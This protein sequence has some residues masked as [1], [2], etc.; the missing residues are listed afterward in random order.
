MGPP[1]RESGLRYWRLAAVIVSVVHVCRGLRRSFYLDGR[2]VPAITAYLF[3]S[4]GH[5]DPAGN[6]L[7]NENKSFIGSYLLGMGF[8]F[9]DSGGQNQQVH[10]VMEELIHIEPRN[11]ERIFPYIGGEEV[12]DSPTHSPTRYVINFVDWP[13]RRTTSANRGHGRR[14]GKG[15]VVTAGVVPLDYPG[16]VAADYP[17][18]LRSLRDE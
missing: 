14:E 9:D 1:G 12:N 18:L 15:G 11:A 10:P 5:N 3:H 17:R 6:S 13:L 4:G 16:S 2:Q 8:T 7:A